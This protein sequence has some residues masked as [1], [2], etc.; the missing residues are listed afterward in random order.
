MSGMPPGIVYM[1]AK[2][3]AA[4]LVKTRLCPPLLPE[5][6]SLL[7]AAFAEDTLRMLAGLDRVQARLALDEGRPGLGDALRLMARCVGVAVEEQGGGDLGAR[8]ARLLERGHAAGVPTVLVGSDCPDMPRD[9]IVAAFEALQRTD[10]V[11]VPASDGGYV[12]IGARRRIAG[13]FDIDA[14]WSSPRVF[15]ATCHAL[16]REGCA[17]E[18]LAPCEDVDD[19]AALGRLAARF[20]AGGAAAAPATARLIGR[21][22][23]EGARF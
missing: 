1:M 6:A 7:A 14:P 21:W 19:A 13:L 16:A 10:A 4:G 18:T 22:R 23:S 9:T 2:A 3:P 5:Q 15:A 8:M 17:F 11:V 20:D 12:L